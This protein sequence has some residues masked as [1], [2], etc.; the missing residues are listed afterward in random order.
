L[1]NLYASRRLPAILAVSVEQ[2][3]VPKPVIAE[4]LYIRQPSEED[5]HD[6]AP[7]T[8]NLDPLID[9]GVLLLTELTG[10]V[11]LR[12]FVQLAALI[13]DCEA[14]CLAIAAVRGL[15]L[16]TDDRRAIQIATDLRVSVL[17]TP[18]LLRKW[19]RRGS[20]TQQEVTDAI[21]CIEKYG[22]FRPHGMCASAR[23][24]AEQRPR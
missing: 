23:W 19:A 11:E 17:T 15:V 3:I 6:V 7:V 13:D 5:P 24:W 21:L 10:D 20:P 2:A 9:S 18:E 8:V 1:I 4:C 22:R 14:A 12:Q 16:A